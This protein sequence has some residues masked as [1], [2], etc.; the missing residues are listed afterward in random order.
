[1]AGHSTYIDCAPN[2]RDL[3]ATYPSELSDRVDLNMDDPTLSE[4]ANIVKGFK[5]I[6]IGHTV[7][8]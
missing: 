1:M 5:G 4:L 6:L 8:S 2:M 7:M 3:M